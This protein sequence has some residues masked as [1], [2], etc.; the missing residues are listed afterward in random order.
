MRQ[1]FVMMP[2]DLLNCRIGAPFRYLVLPVGLRKKWKICWVSWEVVCR[3]TSMGSL[4]VRDLRVVN[5]SLLTKWR[6]RLLSNGHELWKEI[7][8]AFYGVKIVGNVGLDGRGQTRISSVWWKDLCPLDSCSG[9]FSN[10]VVRKVVNGSTT[11]FWK[12]IW[13]GYE[14]LRS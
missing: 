8:A 6:W 3:P 2:T 1:D 14:S 10:A 13:I 4:D 9:W 11:L 7:L 12:D 5:S